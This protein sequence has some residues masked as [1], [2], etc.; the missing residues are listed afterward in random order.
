MHPLSWRPVLKA[1][2]LRV[3]SHTSAARYAAIWRPGKETGR[4]GSPPMHY[5]WRQDELF[6]DELDESV[7][8][9][10]AVYY[11]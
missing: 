8:V 4:S 1:I 2:A 7:Q 6:Q 11:G 9:R 3:H 10:I 5:S